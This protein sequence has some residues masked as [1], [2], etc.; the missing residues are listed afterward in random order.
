VGHFV[1]ETSI[2]ARSGNSGAAA[3]GHGRPGMF[4]WKF[5][6]G[7]AAAI[8]MATCIYLVNQHWPYRYRK[9][10]PLLEQV[11]ASRITVSAYHRIYFPHP[12]FVAKGLT[13]RRSAAP[14]VPPIGSTQ[15]LIVEGRWSD[16]LLFRRRVRLVDVK[17]LHIVIP[18][19]RSRANQEDFPTGSS[20]DFAGPAM[21]VEQLSIHDAVLDLL[22]VNGG[23]YTY[24]IRQLTMRNLRQGQ[25]LSYFVDMQNASPTGR[26]QARGSF[27]PLVPKNLGATP[28]SGKFTF[29]DV[30]LRE[31]GELRGAL[32]AKGQL[33]G[34][35][36][37]IEVYATAE[38]DDFAVHLGRPVAVNGWLRC[39][40][41]G[42]NADVVLHRIE[43]QTGA[44]A[45][46]VR[47]NVMGS[48]N[49]PKATD[50]DFAVKSGRAEDLLHPFLKDRSP[51][52]GVVSL[53]AHAHL[54][55]ASDQVKF[56]ERLRVDGSFV[57]PRERATNRAT[58]KALT[59]FSK[60]AQGLRNAK[61][62]NGDPAGDVLSSLEGRVTIRHG[63][64][65]SQ[66]L[67]FEVPG[68]EAE[69]NGWYDLGDG[70]VRL[71]GKLRMDSDVSHVTTGFKS[72]LLK[73]LV[74][75]FRKNNAGALVP[76]VVT[77]SPDNY[78][79]KQNLLHRK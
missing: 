63:V 79:V 56:L 59:G 22:R 9:V 21:P 66:R 50:L 65:S 37:A 68:A 26:I 30:N 23:K 19:V 2:T 40:V 29:T 6:L 69:L 51:I 61:E 74:P 45:I 27:G 1:T 64:V 33:S 18:P 67:T 47:G 34:A 5:W 73:P 35:L 41:N 48:A 78:D 58:E 4:N 46:D 32:S 20:V 39:T 16:L 36:S 75:F 43:V 55:P 24:P 53:N 28:V 7:A 14:D 71:I 31:I 72:L 17:G 8:L 11:F 57:L 15:D 42:L 52:T 38:S 44:T 60:R 70:K 12:G 49:A 25:A 54:A 3:F 76:I 10:Q 13:L 62:T 77:G